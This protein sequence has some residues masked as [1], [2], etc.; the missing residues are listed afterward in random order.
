M[1]MPG[2]KWHTDGRICQPA[3]FE[4]YSKFQMCFLWL[5]IFS[6]SAVWLSRIRSYGNLLERSWDVCLFYKSS[7]FAYQDKNKY[8]F[9]AFFN[10]CLLNPFLQRGAWIA[11]PENNSLV[12]TWCPHLLLK[13]QN[14]R[15]GDERVLGQND[16]RHRH[17]CCVHKHYCWRWKRNG[18]C[19]QPEPL[20][21]MHQCLIQDQTT[22]G[23]PWHDTNLNP[24]SYLESGPRGFSAGMG[25][26]QRAGNCI[27]SAEIE[28]SRHNE[29]CLQGDKELFFREMWLLQTIAQHLSVCWKKTT[30][31]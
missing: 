13:V 30:T 24:M 29:W 25:L 3:P 31:L 1:H 10:K 12:L 21:C 4:L 27:G 26:S 19:D 7:G 9:S 16:Q 18:V 28:T 17:S 5:R 8:T 20:Q 22:A 11:A 15:L 23:M 6:P 14:H 2:Y